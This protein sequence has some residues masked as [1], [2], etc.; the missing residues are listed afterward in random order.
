VLIPAKLR[1]R[2]NLRPRS[3]VVFGEE[4]GKLTLEST[5]L[6]EVLELRGCLAHVKEDV[7]ALLMEERRK[8]R[9]RDER[10][11]AELL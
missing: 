2:F 8:D 7:E 3:R 9:E 6:K 5:T 1:R 11:F 10:K 4:N